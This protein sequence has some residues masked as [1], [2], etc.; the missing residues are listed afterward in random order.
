MLEALLERPASRESNAMALLCHP[1][2]L[3]HGT[4]QNKIV[5]ALAR[6]FLALRMIAVRFNFRGVGDSEGS[7]GAGEGERE[8]AVAMG[9]WMRQRWPEL[10]LYLGGFSF[11]AAVAAGA[12][13]RLAPAGL[14]TVAL[15]VER[16]SGNVGQPRCPWLII[17]GDQDEVVT[18]DTVI[19]WLN[20]AQPGPELRMLVGA[21]HFFHGRLAELRESVVEFF[22]PIV[23]GHDEEQPR[24]TDA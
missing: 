17:Q 24:R 12:A 4:M 23:E 14:V 3:H 7:Y 15:P 5:H 21:D 18:V 16:L 9:Q 2:P 11:G 19:T 6:A 10:T 13:L 20:S 22:G 8:D 1:H